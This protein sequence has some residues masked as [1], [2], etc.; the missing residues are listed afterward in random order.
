MARTDQ[1][2]GAVISGSGI[3]PATIGPQT[4]GSPPQPGYYPVLT[5]AELETWIPDPP[6]GCYLDSTSLTS[7][8]THRIVVELVNSSLQVIGSSPELTIYV[9]NNPCRASL[10][11]TPDASPTRGFIP[12]TSTAQDVSFAIAPS[13]PENFATYSFTV[14]KGINGLVVSQSGPVSYVRGAT[15]KRL[16]EIGGTGVSS[17]V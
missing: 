8:Q 9:D 3:I 2:H 4:L 13:Q 15:G 12:Y 5:T 14:I 6:P 7:A 1:F 16:V 10:S 17:G 11:V